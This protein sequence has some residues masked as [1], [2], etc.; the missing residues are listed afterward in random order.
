MRATV[1][2]NGRAIVWSPPIATSLLPPVA[3]PSVE[4]HTHDGDIGAAHIFEA[5][6]QRERRDSGDPRNDTRVGGAGEFVR[7]RHAKRACSRLR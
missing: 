1:Q 5:R 6:K 2:S 3:D 7:D 4:R